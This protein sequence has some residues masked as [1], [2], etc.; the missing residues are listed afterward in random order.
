MVADTILYCHRVTKSVEE[1]RS[2]WNVFFGQLVDNYFENRH[3][4]IHPDLV[5]KLCLRSQDIFHHTS[6]K[7][8]AGAASN[9]KIAP[10]KVFFAAQT[11][12]E[13]S[14]VH[15]KTSVEEVCAANVLLVEL[16]VDGNCKAFWLNQCLK[17]WKK[18]VFSYEGPTGVNVT[19]LREA[20]HQLSKNERYTSPAFHV[21]SSTIIDK[22]SLLEATH[23]VEKSEP[24]PKKKRKNAVAD[25]ADE[26]GEKRK[27]GEKKAKGRK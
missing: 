8:V 7:L 18:I 13:S 19:A 17:Q 3:S 15:G 14:M 27:K 12:C 25:S 22:I 16:A 1:S 11:L 23:Q 26:V 4:K 9:M 2:A 24:S 10:F 21:V 6:K 5:R 20:V